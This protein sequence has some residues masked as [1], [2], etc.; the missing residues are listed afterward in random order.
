ML[1][2]NFI[3]IVDLILSTNR[4]HLITLDI[5]TNA[6]WIP[7][8][9]VL[10]RLKQFKNVNINLSIDGLGKVNDY[11]RAPSEWSVVEDSVKQW[12]T[13]ENDYPKIFSIKWAPCVSIYNV[14]QFDQMITWW[15]NLQKSIKNKNWWESI[16]R[17]Q[18][19]DEIEVS[20][21]TTIVNIVHDPKYLS[22]ALY[23]NK[24][25][26]TDKLIAS[27]REYVAQIK[28][29]IASEKDR[30]AVELHIEGMYNK[31]IGILRSP[32]DQEQLKTFIEYTVDLDRL[33][34]EDLRIAIPEV[35]EQIK[36]MA[37]YKGR[38]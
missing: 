28:D 20:Q 16:T 25:E 7:R 3:K 21:L 23:P 2:P 30:W 35:W 29:A 14:W 34:N 11:V 1:H 37:E 5:Y 15:F 32:L 18:T 6:S 4:A 9:K 19:N 13:A 24:R 17:T 33:R 27:K 8:D 22:A 26:L 12:L 10:S 31:I 36:E 38:L